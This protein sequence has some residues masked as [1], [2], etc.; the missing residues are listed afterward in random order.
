MSEKS[1]GEK[2][3]QPTPKRLRDARKKGQVARSTEVVT[4]MSLFSVIA[5]I[6]VTWEGTMESL[7]AMFDKVALL[8]E[9]NFRVNAIKAVD[10]IGRDVAGVLLPLLGVVLLAGIVANCF[11]TG[12]LFSTESLKPNLDKVSPAKGFKRIFSM[13]QVVETIKSILKIVILSILLYFVVYEAIGAYI[14]AISCG[15]PCLAGVTS[16]FM[17][18]TF[19][20]SGLTFIVV[21][22]ADIVYQRHSYI[23]GLMMTKDEIKREYKESEGDPHIKGKRRQLAQELVMGGGGAAARKGSAV[24]VNPT[25]IAVVLRYV[26]DETP[27]PI[28]TAKGRNRNA[29][30]LRTQAEEAGVPVFRNVE[31]ARALY[32]EAEVDTYVPTELFDAV[33]EV[34]A[35]VARN[36]D[37]LYNGPLG[38]GVL[39]ME[40]GDHKADIAKQNADAPP[41]YSS[42]QASSWP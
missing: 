42:N 29:H 12:I 27:L 35:W 16:H 32:A 25:H 2:T 4:T 33:A 23:K 21:A 31:L 3:E 17:F 30:F 5:F 40:A 22:L 18:Q 24:V 39:D 11:Q 26:P 9:G 34:L 28:V 7:L 10:L 13:K 19:V 37:A 36:K 41:P 8:A 6:W 1:S 14:S 38:H 20:Y 15:M